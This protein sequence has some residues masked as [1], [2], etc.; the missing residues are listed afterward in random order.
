MCRQDMVIHRASLEG[1]MQVRMALILEKVETQI[2]LIIKIRESKVTIRA[3][4]KE[5]AGADQ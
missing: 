5:R 2:F 1:G 3:Q 4:I